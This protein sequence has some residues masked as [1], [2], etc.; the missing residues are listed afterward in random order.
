MHFRRA[1]CL[2]ARRF[3]FKN[4]RRCAQRS[5]FQDARCVRPYLHVLN[6]VLLR[7]AVLRIY[8]SFRLFHTVR[9][10]FFLFAFDSSSLSHRRP[11]SLLSYFLLLSLLRPVHSLY[12]RLFGCAINFQYNTESE[13]TRK[14]PTENEFGSC[15]RIWRVCV[16]ACHIS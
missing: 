1:H 7:D 14:N 4:G 5:R 9:E 2:R 11:K 3:L 10:S 12:R 8:I 16:C 6:A 15:D 13:A